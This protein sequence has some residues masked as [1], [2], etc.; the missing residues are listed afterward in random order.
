MDMVLTTEQVSQRTNLTIRQ[1]RN[2]LVAGVLP[3]FKRGIRSWGVLLAELE[4]WLS[5]RGNQK[6]KAA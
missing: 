5:S 2:L 6:P 4:K 1:V 3:G